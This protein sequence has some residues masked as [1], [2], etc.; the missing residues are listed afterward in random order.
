MDMFGTQQ[1][2]VAAAALVAALAASQAASAQILAENYRVGNYTSTSTSFAAIPLANSGNTT[3]TFT[4]TTA[5]ELVRITYNAE[6]AVLGPFQSW[7]AIEITVDGN[8]AYPNSGASFAMCTS[9]DNSGADY[10]WVGAVRQSLYVVPAAGTHRVQV[11][12]AGVSTTSWW[13]GDSS[14][15][16]DH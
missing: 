11:L 16:V 15:V 3:V 4:T 2:L 8:Q 1:R 5:N 6:C 12:G 7:L 9:V 14:I 13:Q 10:G